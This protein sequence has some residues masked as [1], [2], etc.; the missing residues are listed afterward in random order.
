MIHLFYFSDAIIK[1][2]KIDELMK[3]EVKHLHVVI[4]ALH[5]KHK[6]YDDMIQSYSHSHSVDQSEIKRIAG[7]VEDSMAELEESR[8]KLVNLK[9]QKDRLSSVQPPVPFA[10]NGSIS[11]EKTVDKTMGLRDLKDSIEEAKVF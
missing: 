6:E 1:S 8:R 3:E 5:V 10:V 7:D 2:Y 11:P 9:M 4:E